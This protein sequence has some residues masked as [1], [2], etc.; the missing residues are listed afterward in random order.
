MVARKQVLF[1]EACLGGGDK[2]DGWMGTN[3]LA[4]EGDV[5][6]KTWRCVA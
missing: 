1:Q 6:L 3:F 2:G 4:Q 5:G